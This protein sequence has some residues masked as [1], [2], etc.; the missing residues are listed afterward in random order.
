[1]CLKRT[2]YFHTKRMIGGRGLNNPS[3]GIT[4]TIQYKLWR[5]QIAWLRTFSHIG[6]WDYFL[7][8]WDS[9]LTKL[10]FLC[11]QYRPRW[12]SRF[13]R[14][15]S[16]RPILCT[17][18]SW[19]WRSVLLWTRTCCNQCRHTQKSIQGKS[20]SYLDT[21]DVQTLFKFSEQEKEKM[22][23]YD[24]VYRFILQYRIQN[25]PILQILS[26]TFASKS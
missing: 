7:S 3:F 10:D 15:F 25:I 11:F 4:L 1:M 21:F 26:G 16:L 22:A 8:L 18:A 19:G 12:A 5:L 17:A 20:G 23:S 9:P 6:L 2:C 24:K 14:R 13:R